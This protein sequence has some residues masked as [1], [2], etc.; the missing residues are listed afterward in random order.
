MRNYTVN[1]NNKK[2]IKYYTNSICRN[3][4]SNVYTNYFNYFAKSLSPLKGPDLII[5]IKKEFM[6]GLDKNNRFK[7]MYR[8][9]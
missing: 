4:N 3:D 1:F 2:M 5:S 6:F 9:R 7:I 8:N